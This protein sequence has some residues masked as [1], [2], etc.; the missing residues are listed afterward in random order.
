[1]PVILWF[2]AI[3]PAHVHAEIPAPAEGDS[4]EQAAA[5]MQEVAKR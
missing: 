4:K 2:E 5:M 3:T 1:M